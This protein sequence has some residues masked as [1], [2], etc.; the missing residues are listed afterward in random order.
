MVQIWNA[1][2]KEKWN[3]PSGL[4]LKIWTMEIAENH[5]NLKS[6]K[7]SLFRL[8]DF[9]QVRRISDVEQYQ[10]KFATGKIFKLQV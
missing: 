9:E 8:P 5:Y 6:Q 3:N 10:R 4:R 1:Q 2:K 7:N